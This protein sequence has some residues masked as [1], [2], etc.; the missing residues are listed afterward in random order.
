MNFSLDIP[1]TMAAWQI[2]GFGGTDQLKL[3][4]NVKI[5]P[6]LSPRDVL[7]QVHA[8]SVNPIDIEM[9]GRVAQNMVSLFLFHL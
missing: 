5:R 2:N 9:L 1:Q 7:V 4:Q 8:S 6:L 3:A